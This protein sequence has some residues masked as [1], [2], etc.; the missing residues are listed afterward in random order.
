MDALEFLKA[1]R[2]MCSMYNLCE[3]CPAKDHKC[4][5]GEG[6]SDEDFEK[7]IQVVE[8]W[9]REHPVKTRQ[10]V[11]LEMWPNANLTRG[12]IAICPLEID[13]TV[14]CGKVSCFDCIR[15]YWMQEVE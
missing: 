10:S 13:S 8:K 6:S 5:C 12:I 4:Q 1:K 2:E 7:L 14:E 11:F 15:N 3:N 9:Q